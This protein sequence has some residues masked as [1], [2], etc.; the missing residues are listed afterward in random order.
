MDTIIEGD[1]DIIL[2]IE[3]V[4]GKTQEAI[5]GMGDLIIIIIIMV[6]RKL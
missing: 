4:M 5:K 3:V 1:Q 6:K 2:I